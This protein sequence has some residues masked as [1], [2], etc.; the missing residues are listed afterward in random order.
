MHIRTRRATCS[1]RVGSAAGCGACRWPDRALAGAGVPLPAVGSFA[2]W[3]AGHQRAKAGLEDMR[4]R[5]AG[6]HVIGEAA[7]PPGEARLLL[8][9]TYALKTLGE[10]S[11][12][13]P[14]FP[15]LGIFP[16][17]SIEGR[18][19]PIMARPDQPR[20]NLDQQPLTP[21]RRDARQRGSDMSSTCRRAASA[22]FPR[23]GRRWRCLSNAGLR[24]AAFLALHLCPCVC[25]QRRQGLDKAL[26]PSAQGVRWA[27]YQVC[28]MC[29]T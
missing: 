5:R 20:S 13:W 14:F 10:Q 26:L 15:S 8:H 7:A 29:A 1:A 23:L 24:S 27:G 16:G 17:Q 4:S 22:R 12:A 28:I 6:A 3:F 2:L 25:R 19:R 21:T 9:T 11:W 18:I